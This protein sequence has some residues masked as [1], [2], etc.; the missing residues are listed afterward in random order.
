MATLKVDTITS[1]D[2]PTVSITDGASISGVT[3]FSSDINIA[4]Y[5]Y[6]DGDTNT[7]FGFPSADT[8][9]AE[10]GGS[11][12]LSIDNAGRVAIAS[13]LSVTGIITA[14]TFKPTYGS[15]GH[16]NLLINGDM[17]VAQRMDLRGITSSADSGYC[18]ID[19]YYTHYSGGSGTTQW[20][21]FTPGDE[22]NGSKH[23]MRYA[24][25]SAS[26]Y[27]C[28]RCPIED[29]RTI[30]NE[31]ITVSFDAKYVTNAPNG[32]LTCWFQTNYG[33]SGTTTGSSSMKT[34][35]G[36]SSDIH[37]VLP[38][39]TT[40][41]ARYSVTFTDIPG[42]SGKTIGDG[43][44][45]EFLF[46]QGTATGGTAWTLDIT[47]IQVERGY[48][49]T[50]FEWQHVA[51]TV[52]R[53]QRYYW[54]QKYVQ[55]RDDHDSVAS[56]TLITTGVV[57]TSSRVLAHLYWPTT[58]RARPMPEFKDQ[59][60]VQVLSSDGTWTTSTSLGMRSDMHGARFDINHGGTLTTHSAA[61]VRFTGSGDYFAVNAEMPIVTGTSG[62]VY[63]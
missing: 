14:A 35:N 28:I 16:R 44:F 21:T 60:C 9:T 3:T 42:L 13:S 55:M 39:L 18:S 57:Y 45:V 63:S 1:A 52:A 6:H 12:R 37:G 58:M 51:D 48:T 4:D 62:G 23:Y 53:C 17:S 49:A 8:I 7:R 33:E 43:S 2:T 46:G 26:D 31:P 41:W 32:G 61:E 30:D 11:Q 36:S 20:L 50:P 47:N 59:A 54:G 24:V 22:R 10:T 40:S 38:S 34:F 15:T 27:T 5:V 29:V 25:A 19:R 56:E